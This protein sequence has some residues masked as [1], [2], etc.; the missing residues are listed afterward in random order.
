M[1]EK[2][3]NLIGT[4]DSTATC[5][6]RDAQ[7]ADLNLRREL[8]RNE[9]GKEQPV[10]SQAVLNIDKKTRSNLFPWRG[11]FSPQL[12]EAHLA[13]YAKP[14][15][16]ILDPFV[17]SGTV[18][19]E[20]AKR[21][22]DV[23]GAE[24]NPAAAVM[25]R[26]YKLVRLSMPER[27]SVVT[28]IDN[29]VRKLGSYNDLPLFR[30]KDKRKIT[31]ALCEARSS[32][33][34]DFPRYLLEALVVILDFQAGEVTA[35]RLNS[36]W[37]NLRK[38]VF[39]LPFSK[40][41]VS[42]VL[43][44]AR[45]LPIDS[46]SIDFILT[47]P[48]YINVFNYHQQYRASIE[49]LDWEVLPLAR[50]EIGAN[51]KHRGNRF[52]TM[53]QYCLDM[54]QVFHELGRVCQPNARAIFVVG[55][56]SNIRKTAFYN[57]QLLHALAENVLGLSVLLQQERVF[58]NRFGQ[59]IY[60]DILHFRVRPILTDNWLE[61]SRQFAAKELRAAKNRVPDDVLSDYKDALNRIAEVEPSPLID[62]TTQP[63]L[64]VDGFL[65]DT[66]T[67]SLDVVANSTL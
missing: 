21:H 34:N 55:R 57:G 5:S 45:R 44:D 51:R 2:C 12:I 13:A 54:A 18:L 50:S 49:A 47:S 41:Q 7:Y 15:D 8:R 36:S 53:I 24:I 14:G 26:T 64:L 62:T 48:P 3:G 17:G 25:A 33:S 11:Q 31:E 20:S 67:T 66:F 1:S 32:M 29:F 4:P 39:G 65:N 61:H 27:H 28:V 58:Q 38:M 19:V 16:A 42:V 46:G 37:K 10:L 56:E 9:H 22:H 30:S 60:E 59:A 43:S 6:K 23:Y 52:L 63:R 35:K 40:S